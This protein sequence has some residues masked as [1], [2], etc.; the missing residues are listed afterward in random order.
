M[1]RPNFVVQVPAS[2]PDEAMEPFF[3]GWVWRIPWEEEVEFD[4]T[5]CEF[6]A[7]WALALFAA[8][9]HWLIEEHQKKV[10]VNFD[11]DS[12]VGKYLVNSGFCK[13]FGDTE[14]EPLDRKGFTVCMQRIDSSGQIRE[15]TKS[16]GLLL[17]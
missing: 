16:I 17:A 3:R 6:L 9:G 14:A 15:I 8:Y 7:P 4:F 11:P 5:S 12:T 10:C 2:L 13:V 1:D